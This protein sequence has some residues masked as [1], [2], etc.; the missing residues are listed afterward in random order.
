MVV[1]ELIK[2]MYKTR[3]S[4]AGSAGLNKKG[5]TKIRRMIVVLRESTL[6]CLISITIITNKPGALIYR[7]DCWE[8]NE[9]NLVMMCLQQI[10]TTTIDS[11][12]CALPQP[13]Q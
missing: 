12:Y 7:K 3:R 11:R 2:F 13:K 5:V 8:G 4:V 1:I 9:I 6:A 10:Y